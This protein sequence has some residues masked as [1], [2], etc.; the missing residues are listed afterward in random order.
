MNQAKA[1]II[2]GSAYSVYDNEKEW[3]VNFRKWIAETHPKFPHLK[4]LGI[5]F[6]E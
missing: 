6:G 2:P 1:I 5:C 4:W 3:I